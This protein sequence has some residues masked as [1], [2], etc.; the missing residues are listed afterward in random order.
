MTVT[1]S[2]GKQLA[3]KITTARNSRNNECLWEKIVTLA[4]TDEDFIWT[5]VIHELAP[6]GDA[7]SATGA[8]PHP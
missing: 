4:R 6:Y 7:R 2:I 5:L 3:R 1:G 8:E